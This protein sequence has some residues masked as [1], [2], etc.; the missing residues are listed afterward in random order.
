MFAVCAYE[1]L[2][3]GE[4][5]YAEMSDHEVLPFLE[6][7]RRLPQPDRE[8]GV[9]LSLMKLRLSSPSP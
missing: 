1:L 5:P 7:G 6:A 3:L 9:R 2:S 4:I 8:R